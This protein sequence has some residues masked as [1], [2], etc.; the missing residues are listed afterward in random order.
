MQAQEKRL[1]E[2]IP[3]EFEGGVGLL[4]VTIKLDNYG[5]ADERLVRVLDVEEESPAAVSGL[6]KEKDFLLGT[7]TQNF[8]NAAVLAS[9]LE[10]S[11]D[12]VVEIYVYN[13]DSDMVRVVGLM[14]SFSWGGSGTCKLAIYKL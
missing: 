3:D 14:P 10:E 8:D 2:L 4:G 1:V 6:V 13:S 11:I 5:G 9:V 12:Q 7:T